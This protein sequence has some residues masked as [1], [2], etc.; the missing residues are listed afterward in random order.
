MYTVTNQ[1]PN[2]RAAAWLVDINTYIQ[3]QTCRTNERERERER[4]GEVVAA[5]LLPTHNIHVSHH[6]RNSMVSENFIFG[7]LHSKL[8]E[9]N[10]RL[11]HGCHTVYCIR[12]SL[13][14]CPV[15]LIRRLD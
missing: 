6:S 14:R 5:V 9:R 2:K 8:H 15:S 7:N 11:T 1:L 3:T 10:V 13:N 4:E 12:K